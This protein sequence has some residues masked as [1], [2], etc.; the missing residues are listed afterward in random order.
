MIHASF[1]RFAPALLLLGALSLQG[2]VKDSCDM[3]YTYMK[4][5]PV[6]MSQAEF[7][8][9]V[10]VEPP[11]AVRNPG[12]IYLQ[13][14]FLFVNEPGQGVHIIDN[15][16]PEAP[17]P[18]AFLRVPGTY[19][20]A[21]NCNDLYLDSS[22]DLLVFDLTN[23]AEPVLLRRV[24]N[25]F[26]HILSYRG[27]Q[28][29][30]RA[31]IVVGWEPS[32]E[33]GEYDCH[34]GIPWEW[35]L[36]QIDPSTLA[37]DNTG[38]ARTVNPAVAG[39]AG[40]MSRFTVMNDHLYVVTPQTL[41]VYD[42]TVCESPTHLADIALQLWQGEAE[43]VSTLDHY[44][45]IGTNMGMHIFDAAAP[46][47]PV[48]LSSFDHVQ[49]CDPVVGQGSYAYVT[50]RNGTDQPCGPN[51]SNQLDVVDISRVQSPQLVAT[52]PMTNP[53]GLGIDGNLLFIA[54][55]EAGLRIFD[56]SDPA[57]VGKTP[58]AHFPAMQGYDVIAAQGILTFVGANGIAQYDY[59]DP[60][61]IRQLSVI[62][63]E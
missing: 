36:N 42:V 35:E 60:Q 31:G 34:A 45:L 18:L 9:G 44:L 63:V 47:D 54:D 28:A 29:D 24:P 19:D 1:L 13:D 33:T 11:Q 38:N 41:Q 53:H 51:F 3:T 56:A 12:K 58:I 17:Q 55:G 20:L 30:P 59:Q 62:P 8:Q 43:M 7:L 61:N 57:R 46:A 22:T 14:Q 39:Q 48:M 5:N 26:P 25:A 40:S 4:Y 2:C 6:Y 15:K 50:L 52:F 27:F 21:I 10:Q 16:N 49:A 32:V 23:P 37:L